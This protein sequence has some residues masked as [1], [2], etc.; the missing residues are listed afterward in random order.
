MLLLGSIPYPIRPNILTQN[1]MHASPCVSGMK[2][3]KI[4]FRILPPSNSFVRKTPLTRAMWEVL[5]VMYTCEFESWQTT[6]TVKLSMEKD[7]CAQN[8]CRFVFN[9]TILY[10]HT[11]TIASLITVR[12]RTSMCLI[13]DNLHFPFKF[14]SLF[15][16]VKMQV[17][18]H[19]H[20]HVQ[21]CYQT[22]RHAYT[23]NSHNWI[24]MSV[25]W[26]ARSCMC[27]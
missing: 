27:L 11:H 24:H 2:N 21:N 23:D 7:S 15:I 13:Y 1:A 14:I 9:F 8:C 19:T 4:C 10:M 25:W 26:R 22:R 6:A 12:V 5:P 20:S 16:N 17:W 18:W 3:R